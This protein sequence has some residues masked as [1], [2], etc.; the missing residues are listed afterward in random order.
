VRRVLPGI[1]AAA[2]VSFTAWLLAAADVSVNVRSDAPL[3]AMLDELA[4]S[5]TLKLNDLDKPYFV[6]YAISDTQQ[7][8]IAG[9]FG[10]L[11]KSNRFRVRQPRLAVRVGDY[12]F[13]NTNSVYSN[14]PR[15]GLFP[16]DDD[17]QAIRTQLW[18]GTD[19]LY[20]AAAEEIAHKRAALREIAEPDK[21]PDFAPVKA[22]QF[23]APIPSLSIDQT[24]WEQL[25]RQL[26]ARFKSHP[27]LVG[28]DVAIRAISSTY[29]LVNSEGS[30]LQIP[31]ELSEI[32]I[33]SSA[34]APD[35]ARVWNHQFITALRSSQFPSESQLAKTVDDIGTETDALAKAPLA[36]DYSG[37]VLFEQ[38]AAAEMMAQV[39]TDAIRIQRKPLAP[40]GSNDRGVQAVESV[41]ASRMGAKVAPDWL[42]IVDNP[43][44]QH[45][46][47]TALAG[48]Y[49]VDDEGVPAQRV[50]IIDKGTLAAFLLSREPVRNFNSSNGHG[51][52]PGAF[53]AEQ[54]V[55]GNLFIE[56]E[57][58]ITESALKARLLKNV[59]TA[60]L[61]YGIL[62]RRL[63]FPSTANF[64]DLQTMARQLQKNGYARTLNA[65]LLAYRIYPD[66]REELVRGLRFKEFSAKDLRDLDAASD[67]AYVLNYVNNGSSFD[68]ADTGSDATTSSVISPS[69]LFNSLDLSRVEEEAG[70]LPVVPPP[71]LSLLT[72]AYSQ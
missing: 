19:A 17:Y 70:R 33:R 16:V 8:Y 18:L 64:E 10:G 58:P 42:S 72:H 48:H 11:T 20:K 43:R 61:K 30:I 9:S 57:H 12:S 6:E 27:N 67:R 25:V 47:G 7:V 63:D 59:K 71:T 66:G 54:A 40:P 45:F 37:P 44:E 50:E 49:D 32:E 26:S 46:H 62:I 65:P 4:R 29:R 23:I 21:T 5:K 39:L 41:W 69:L 1:F 31:Q 28:S 35:G 56:S 60:G 55:I 22:V 15:M 14:T 38:E 24:H 52:L 51:R 3:R 2:V 68:L 13:D 34:L 36:D 53:G